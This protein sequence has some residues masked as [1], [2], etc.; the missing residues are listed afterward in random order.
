MG[1][2]GRKKEKGKQRV[3]CA[4]GNWKFD[5][6]CVFLGPTQYPGQNEI[7]Y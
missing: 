3:D 4:L 6:A 7:L 2:K 5:L 1:Y